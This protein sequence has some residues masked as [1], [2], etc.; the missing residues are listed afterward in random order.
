SPPTGGGRMS[1]QDRL[2]EFSRE[3]LETQIRAGLPWR[4]TG[5]DLHLLAVGVAGFEPTTSSSRTKRATKLRYT[6]SVP[7]N[8]SGPRVPCEPGYPVTAVAASTAT[9]RAGRRTVPGRSGGDPGRRTR[10]ARRTSRASGA[11]P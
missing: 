8:S 11:G 6:P 5:P 3:G 10:V 1:A 9:P 7:S 4:K 2:P